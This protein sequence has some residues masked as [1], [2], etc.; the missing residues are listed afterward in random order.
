MMIITVI[1]M[2]RSSVSKESACSVGDPGL[3]P[4]LG[5]SPGEGNGNPLQCSCLENSMDREAWRATVHG[6]AK[7]RHDL[8]T[9]SSS[10]HN[11]K[12]VKIQEHL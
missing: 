6:V 8:A 9:K 10:C 4:G 3:I 12:F 7:V 2:P 11:L 5:R 1:V